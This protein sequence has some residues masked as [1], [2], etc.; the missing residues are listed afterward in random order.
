MALPPQ[1]IQRYW[2]FSRRAFYGPIIRS[3]VSSPSAAARCLCTSEK[4]SMS[5]YVD[6]GNV[7]IES[8]CSVDK[9]ASALA[10]TT[11]MIPGLTYHR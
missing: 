1:T 6:T 5:A 9:V 4:K 2:L 11:P 7:L 8:A 10:T 3:S